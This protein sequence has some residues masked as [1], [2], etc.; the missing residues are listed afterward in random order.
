MKQLVT[1]LHNY[2]NLFGF[3]SILDPMIFDVRRNPD[4]AHSNL[5]V[6]KILEWIKLSHRNLRF[7]CI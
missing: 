7:Y 4:I 5:T 2:N 1:I 3:H 6:I